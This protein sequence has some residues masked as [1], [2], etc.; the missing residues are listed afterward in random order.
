MAN[1][2]VNP[3]SRL[4]PARSLATKKPWPLRTGP[5]PWCA[6]PGPCPVHPSAFCFVPLSPFAV[7]KPGTRASSRKGR[8]LNGGTRSLRAA[9]LPFPPA[10]SLMPGRP[11]CPHGDG[12]RRNIT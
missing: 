8:E 2:Q 12:T 4:A 6:V 1:G 7:Q 10:F 3:C 9:A 5:A 11:F